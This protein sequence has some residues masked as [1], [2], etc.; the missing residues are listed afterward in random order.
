ME[1]EGGGTASDTGGEECM[2]GSRGGERRSQRVQH[3]SI[4]A[5]IDRSLLQKSPPTVVELEPVPRHN[6]GVYTSVVV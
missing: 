1:F 2:Q 3:L 6:R 4:A 5:V